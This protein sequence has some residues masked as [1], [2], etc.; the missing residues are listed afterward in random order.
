MK[1]QNRL[2]AFFMAARIEYHWH[3]ILRGRKQAD[4]LLARGAAL[5]CERMLRL[6]RR[7]MH[8]GLMAKKQEKAYEVM[9]CDPVKGNI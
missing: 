2:K 8:H 3:C 5:N 9:F 6:N 1:F 7:L 4:R